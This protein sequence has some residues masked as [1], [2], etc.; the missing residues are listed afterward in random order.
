MRSQDIA[1]VGILLACAAIA[2]LAANIIPTPIVSNLAIGFYCLAIILTAPRVGEAL[3]IGLVAG[4]IC[5]MISHSIYPPANLISEPVGVLV[6]LAVYSLLA[7]R[8]KYAAGT[9]TFLATCASGFTFVLVALVMAA[10]AIS[11][12]Y[13]GMLPFFIAMS[14]IVIG[15]ALAN[16]VVIGLLAYPAIRVVQ[17]SHN[18]SPE[19]ERTFKEE[20]LFAEVSADDFTDSTPVVLENV[21]YKY[22]GTNKPALSNISLQAE[23]GDFILITGPT[24]SGKTTLCNTIAGI[25]HHE[26]GGEKEGCV[27]LFG[28]DIMEYDGLAAISAHVCIVFDDPD[29]QLIFTSVEEEIS[30][31]LSASGFNPEE[32][33]SRIVSLLSSLSLLDLRDR[34]VSA[35]SGGQKQRV[36]IAAALA[37]DRPVLIL[38]EPTAELDATATGCVVSLLR[39]LA[40]QGCTI[41]VADHT[42]EVYADAVTKVL[43]MERGTIVREG[44]TDLAHELAT[45]PCTYTTVPYVPAPLNKQIIS[46]LNLNHTYGSITALELVS[47]SVAAGEFIAILGDNGSGKTTLIKHLNGLLYPTLGSVFV[48]GINTSQS[49]ITELVK[50]SGLLFQNPDTMLFA[51]SVYDEVAFGTVNTRSAV[52]CEEN[53][54]RIRNAISALG[55]S[56]KEEAYPR[57]LSRGERQRLAIACILA[58][59]TPIL[60]LDEP[61]TGLDEAESELVMQRLREYQN[62]G[63]TIVMVTHNQQMAY[64][65]A[66]RVITMEYGIVVS[67][68]IVTQEVA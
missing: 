12:K 63:H 20:A 64:R 68:V 66:N 65:H 44:G 42:P 62:R 52:A 34:P 51:E 35:L 8:T 22:P 21:H 47:L 3:G 48:G 60:I 49:T 24:A 41:I 55:L 14:P 5:A 4:I 39:K 1:I 13:S 58:M 23:K 25:T 7:R 56:G 37:M 28:R 61:T 19:N 29:S 38:D 10:P 67:D 27:K 40:D 31:S 9:A 11:L 18:P 46:I 17:G 15:T 2:R 33:E 50:T 45:I 59:E 57:S 6:C 54:Q 43:V 36:S 53:D 32:I 16:S 30:S 26:C